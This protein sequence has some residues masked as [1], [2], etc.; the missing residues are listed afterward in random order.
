VEANE[1]IRQVASSSP[2]DEIAKAKV[3]FDAGTITAAEFE[4]IKRKAVL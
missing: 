3:L 4:Q 1:Y 2:S